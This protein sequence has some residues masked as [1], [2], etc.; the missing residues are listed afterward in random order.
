MDTNQTILSKDTLMPVSFA[1]SLV[2]G[3]F[4]LSSKL[5]DI[6]VKLDKMETQL[7]D[8]WSSTEMENWSLKLKMA[9]PEIEIPEV[10]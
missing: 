10:R 1:I 3:T 7:Q 6:E 4:W 5:T 8:Q 9:N 2:I